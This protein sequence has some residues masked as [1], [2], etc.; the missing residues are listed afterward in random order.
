[1]KKIALITILGLMA[2][3]SAYSQL[4]FGVRGGVSINNVKMI[5]QENEQVQVTYDPG[6][7]FHFGLTGQLKISKLF[8]QPDLLFSTTTNEVTLDDINTNGVDAVTK[9][10]FNKFDMPILVG[11]KFG[12]FKIGAGPVATKMI[13]SK[14]ELLDKYE[15]QSNKATLGYQLCAGFDFKK[16]NIELRYEDNLSN[17]GSGVKVA[18]TVYDFDQRMH[19]VLLSSALYF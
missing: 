19:Q 12:N 7:G 18:G 3:G 14:S 2:A 1:M 9:Q 13:K 8:I 5:Q 4:K 11:F 17:L 15:M 16:F 6:M 10:H